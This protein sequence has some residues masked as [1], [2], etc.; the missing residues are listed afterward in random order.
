M[1]EGVGTE[2]VAVLEKMALRPPAT[3]C[4]TSFIVAVC[5]I[6]CICQTHASHPCPKCVLVVRDT[7]SGSEVLWHVSKFTCISDKAQRELWIPQSCTTRN[8]G[9]SPLAECKV[10]WGLQ[11][12]HHASTYQKR[13]CGHEHDLWRL[14]LMNI[15]TYRIGLS[16]EWDSMGPIR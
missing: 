8:L 3:R 10:N 7:K 4:F 6:T 11:N 15:S 14:S 1:L 9:T 13:V 12:Y 16:E 5:C 2:P